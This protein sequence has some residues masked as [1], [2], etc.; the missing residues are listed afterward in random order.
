MEVGGPAYPPAIKAIQAK[1]KAAGY[2]ACHLPKE[3]GGAGLPFMY[4][5]FVNEIL[6]AGTTASSAL[7]ACWDFHSRTSPSARC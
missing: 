7:S 3:A 2:W 6:T 4:Y 1:A 5:V